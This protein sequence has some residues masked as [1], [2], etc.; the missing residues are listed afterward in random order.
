MP[1][2]LHPTMKHK[3]NAPKEP[4]IRFG[5]IHHLHLLNRLFVI[6]ELNRSALAKLT[7]GEFHPA[8]FRSPSLGLVVSNRHTLAVSI[9]RESN[10][11]FY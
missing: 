8:V 10:R 7:V 9:L 2:W 4:A 5:L 11:D 3:N 1:V 6:D